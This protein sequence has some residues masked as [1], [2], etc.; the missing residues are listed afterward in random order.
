MVWQ[1]EYDRLFI[2]GR[3]V[4]PSTDEVIEVIS[5]YT[6]K[7]IARVPA[8]ANA[9]VDVAVAAARTA[10]DRGPW[11]RMPLADRIEVMGRLSAQMH[12]AETSMAEL[13]TAEMGCPITQS[14]GIQ[15]ARP[16]SIVDAMI[17][18]ARDHPFDEIR[19]APSGRARVTREPVGVLAAIVPWNAPHLVTMMKL[20]PA[21]LAG[22]TVVLK[23]SPETP[24]DAYLLAELLSRAGLPDGVVNIVPAHR[25]PS[26]Y[27]V[28]HPGVDMV[29]FTG[30]T[31]AGRRIGSLCGGLV[32]RVAL[33]LG[34]KSAAVV[35]DDADLESTV[36][37]LRTGA[38]RNTGQVCSSKT[39]VVVS[40]RRAA[41]FADALRDAT[42][43]MPVG[44][45]SDPR[46]EF[47][48]LVSSRQREAVEG[49]IRSGR[50]EGATVVLGGGRPHGLDTGWFVEPT[51][52]AGVRPD[53]RIAQEEIFGP[54]L[55]IL[56]Y[57]TEDEA[58]EIANDSSY[59]LNGAIFTADPQHAVALAER[60]RTGTVEINGNPVGLA[61]PVGGVKDSGVGRELGPEGF[62]EFIEF[63]SI[64]LPRDLALG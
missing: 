47:G 29:S 18:L 56:E 13:V 31:G 23:P 21:L 44:D 43:G 48:P 37:A 6:E 41:E 33:E 17:E 53:M 28:T 51:I 36:S 64:G 63:K 3:W 26:E 8:G 24:L 19:E 27:L 45:P 38:F 59:G 50:A 54:V 42:E 11:P 58:I 20:A 25:E 60:I 34:G 9:D 16:R 4:T 2:G 40:R 35:L 30:S 1:G 39:R 15:A 12:A 7:P 46:T 55:S 62:D 52:F 5:P 10:F 57:D 61:A 14:H 22:C 32:R 49:Y